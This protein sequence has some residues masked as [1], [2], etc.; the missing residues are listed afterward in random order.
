MAGYELLLKQ[1]PTYLK[2]KDLAQD[3]AKYGVYPDSVQTAAGSIFFIARG[4]DQ[5]VLV[6]SGPKKIT[7]KFEGEVIEGV[8]NA[9]ACAL[10]MANYEVMKSYFPYMTPVSH[11]ARSISFGLGDRLGLASAGHLRLMKEHPQVFPVIAQQSMRELNLTGRT[12]EL[13]LM[14][15]AWAVFQEGFT[16]GF[17]ADGDHLKLAKEVQYALDCGFTMITLDCSENID[18]DA[19]ALDL[20]GL[21]AKYLM[22]D[23]Q[24]RKAM[25]A[26][27]LDQTIVLKN[28]VEIPFSEELYYQTV[29]VYSK[30]I[31]FAAHIFFDII[32][33]CPRHIDFE[34]SIDE[35]LVETEPA[36]HY[37]VA[38]E[39]IERGVDITS[40]APRFVGEFQKG[41]D[42]MGDI[43]QFEK[44]F[45]LHERIAE[46]FGYKIS[47]HS[48]SDKFSVF[49]I[50][51]EKTGGRYHIKT[52]GTNWLEF[53]RL[54]AV[55]DAEL[56]RRIYKY[57]LEV[58]DEACKF[59]HVSGKKENCPDIDTLDPEKFGE[60]F[61]VE[62][63]DTRQLMHI[64]YGY[65]LTAK[66]ED[67]SSR[68]K[69]DMYALGYRC[70]EK[71]YELLKKHIGRH[72]STLGI[73]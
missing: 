4:D 30:A 8:E 23:A 13:V 17:G 36:A 71:Y 49:P 25:E 70:E 73:Q 6:V 60:L 33:P 18:N 22:L 9:V 21:K 43:A 47:V 63:V 62:N 38:N 19:Y 67:G 27:Y 35:T 39:L 31:D 3:F 64:T 29:V 54:I 57:A 40:V 45:E 66:N 11:K 37:I 5:K 55:S 14:D 24:Y 7:D 41:V 15:A 51:G 28:G 10:N 46:H 2:T 50:V 65:I 34:V 42:Y 48:G 44:D 52:A 16:T 1:N 56:F 12:Y 69:D 72:V 53:A 26:K 68:F 61:D 59:Y 32:E 58:F 20:N